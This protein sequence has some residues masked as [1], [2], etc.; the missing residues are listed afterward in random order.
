[1]SDGRELITGSAGGAVAHAADARSGNLLINIIEA[2]RDPTVDAGKMQ[3][4]AELAMKMQDRERQAQFNTDLMDAKE[5]LPAIFKRG[6]SD[7][8]RYAKFEDMQRVVDPILW[9]HNLSIDFKVRSGRDDKG[10]AEITAIPVLRHRNGWV[11]VGEPL[12]GP[13]DQG[14]GRSGIQAVGS[15]SS[16][17]KRHA[18]KAALNIREDG[19]DT[20]GVGGRPDD[21]P[22]D[23]QAMLVVD[24]QDAASRGEYAAWFKGLPARDKAWMIST[25]HHNGIGGGLALPGDERRD[26]DEPRRDAAAGDGKRT[27][28]QMVADYKLRVAECADRNALRALQTDTKIS[29]WVTRLRERDPELHAEVVE[30]NAA[31]FA[32]LAAAEGDKMPNATDDGQEGLGL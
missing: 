16:Y 31:R 17:L 25:G 5:Q 6:K 28:A 22:N 3:A 13:P 21:R 12:S 11:E 10:Q 14:P 29:A 32:Q 20:D 26:Q 27:P 7:K 15:S 24:A 8:H 9:A 23:R 30:A 18:M 4:M 19:E 2:A 1:M